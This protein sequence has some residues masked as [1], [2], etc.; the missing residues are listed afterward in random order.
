MT[1]STLRRLAVLALALGTAFAWTAAAHATGVVN[2][3]TC[4]TLNS[5][6]TTYRLTADITNC[7]DCL[8]VAANKITIDLQGHS[9]TTTCPSQGA[10]ITDR[11]VPWELTV[12]KNGAV[13]GS[14]PGSTSSPA[15]ASACLVSRRP[16]VMWP[17]F[18]S[19][20]AAW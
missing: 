8:I 1:S 15:R 4:Q 18:A 9:I 7:G 2:I 6:N 17:E 5:P 13:A 16:L 14:G 12:V 20:H 3:S 19:A 10:A 11:L